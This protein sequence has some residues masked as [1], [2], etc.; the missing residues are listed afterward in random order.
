MEKAS[1]LYNSC[2]VHPSTNVR[3]T[4]DLLVGPTT[5]VA[6]MH[7]AKNHLQIEI[8]SCNSSN[9]TLTM[10][11]PTGTTK[12]SSGSKGEEASKARGV[13]PNTEPKSTVTSAVELATK[14]TS[15]EKVADKNVAAD[16]STNEDEEAKGGTTEV[17]KV[18]ANESGQEQ[19]QE[20][21]GDVKQEDP[22]EEMPE[23]DADKHIS[24]PTGNLKEE[25]HSKEMPDVGDMPDKHILYPGYAAAAENSSTIDPLLL[26]PAHQ[27]CLNIHLLISGAAI[28]TS[29]ERSKC[30]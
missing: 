24:H 3:A 1:L 7:R 2:C 26:L 14:E 25:E 30:F 19:E 27:N 23:E 17:Q 28:S 11:S 8:H 9:K 13:K 6:H 20:P 12:P 5:D 10:S 21:T 22:S 18:D 15:V 29:F 16:T 4:V